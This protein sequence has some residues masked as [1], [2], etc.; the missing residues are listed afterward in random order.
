MINLCQKESKVLSKV[1][2]S[3]R[4]AG[5]TGAVITD[6]K[7][8]TSAKHIQSQ[9]ERQFVN[10]NWATRVQLGRVITSGTQLSMNGLKSYYQSPL[11]VLNV[12]Q[13]KDEWNYPIQVTR[14]DVLSKTTSGSVHAAISARMAGKGI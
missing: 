9:H 4:R 8:P 12:S 3:V 11:P 1:T 7:I 5:K 13:L 10:Q 2:T 6:L 14:I